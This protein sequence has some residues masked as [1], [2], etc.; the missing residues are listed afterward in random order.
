VTKFYVELREKNIGL[1]N[2]FARIGT[3]CAKGSKTTVIQDH[4]KSSILRNT[5]VNWF[6][7]SSEIY[8]L[9]GCGGNGYSRVAMRNYFGTGDVARL[10]GKSTKT[11]QAAIAAGTLQPDAI[12]KHGVR[13]DAL[14]EPETIELLRLLK[15]SGTSEVICQ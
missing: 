2:K 6:I 4:M 5:L 10:T 12:V 11:I 8:D 13:S 15:A 9:N 7:G 3:C 14:F 1:E